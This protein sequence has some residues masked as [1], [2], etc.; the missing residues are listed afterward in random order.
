MP[1]YVI[2]T[3]SSCDLNQEIAEQL[4][5]KVL[6]LSFHTPIHN[7]APAVGNPPP[8]C[9]ANTLMQVTALD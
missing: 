9:P 5:L 6:P 1:N 3:D 2:V 4:E 8:A 7:T